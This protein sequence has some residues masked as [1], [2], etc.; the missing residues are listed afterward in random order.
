MPSGPPLEYAPIDQISE[1]DASGHCGCSKGH[2]GLTRLCYA[3]EETMIKT[4]RGC[5]SLEIN[6]A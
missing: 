2:A 4:N 3:F 6:I 5:E 1:K